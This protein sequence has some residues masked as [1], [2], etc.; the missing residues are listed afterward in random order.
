MI[1]RCERMRVLQEKYCLW[2]KAKF[3]LEQGGGGNILCSV[4]R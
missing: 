3:E 4:K 2:G 1:L